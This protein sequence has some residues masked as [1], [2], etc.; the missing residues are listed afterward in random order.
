MSSAG[1]GRVVLHVGV[2]KSGTSFLQAT[3]RANA[4]RLAAAG[5]HYPTHEHKGLFH[6]ALELTG[7]HPGW[8]VPDRRVQ[9][10]WERLCRDARVRNG[11]TVLSSELFS[12]VAAADVPTALAGLDGLEVHLV[13]T[14]RDLARQLPAEWQEGIKHGRTLPFQ[15][16]LDR[17]T[18]PAR[19]HPHARKF[20]R[21]QDVADLLDRWGAALPPQRVHLVTV[22]P[23]G[24]ARDLLWRRFCEVLEVDPEVATLP[25]AGANTSLGVTAVDVLRRVN[26]EIRRNRRR[27]PLL[28]RTV[29]QVLVNGALRRDDSPRVSTP[30]AMLP[31]LEEIT[32]TWVRRVKDAGYDVVGDLDDLRPRPVESGVPVRHKVPAKD[33]RDLAVEAVAVLTAEV[34]ALRGQVRE[35]KAAQARAA[36]PPPPPPPPPSRLRR[37]RRAVRRPAGTLRRRKP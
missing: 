7:N 31:R 11:T 37:L 1:T 3:L 22:P 16:F 10:S 28:R 25:G 18:D 4:E 17:V 33:S 21:H 30:D 24:A 34:A 32:E 9:G 14:A 5:V 26:R 19:S 20:W 13:V 36:A 12:N 35:L 2:P 8:G 23:P 27:P 6:A 29:K 15:D